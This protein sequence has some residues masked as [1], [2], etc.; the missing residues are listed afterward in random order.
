MRPW[1]EKAYGIPPERV[2]GSSGVTKFGMRSTGPV[3]LKAPT[4]E[5]IDP[6]P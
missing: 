4:M 2:A 3:L 5:F 6:F 1:V